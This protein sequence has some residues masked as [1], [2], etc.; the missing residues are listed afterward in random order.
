MV[1]INKTY[2]NLNS[3]LLLARLHPE[4]VAKVFLYSSANLS[5]IVSQPD[6]MVKSSE[7]GSTA[8]SISAVFPAQSITLFA[9]PVR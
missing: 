2:G 9:I 7:P 6:A 4:G 8:S 5:G 3:T 1:V